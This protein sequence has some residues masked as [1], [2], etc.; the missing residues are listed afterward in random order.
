MQPF[1]Q[2]GGAALYLGDCRDVLPTLARDSVDLLVT[3]PPYGQRWQGRDRRQ[4]GEF[5]VLTGDDGTLDVPAALTLALKPLRRG[6]HVYIFGRFEL[7]ALPLAS[8][9]EL[10]WDKGH[11]GLGNLAIPWGLSHEPITFAVHE[12]SAVNRAKESGRLAARVRRGS[13]LRCPRLNSVAV[14]QH[15]TEK[16]VPL[17]RQLIESS[18]LI[19]ETVLDPFA[20]VGSTLVAAM[21]EGRQSIGIEVE[22]KYCET[23]AKRLEQAAQY[24]AALPLGVGA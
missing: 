6:R 21:L 18:S 15:P 4:G 11:Q 5:A 22:E 16:P 23:A 3:D 9:V 14:A 12:I 7:S 17:L 8:P 13:V 1:W 2:G 19:G 10:V 20:G 24:Q